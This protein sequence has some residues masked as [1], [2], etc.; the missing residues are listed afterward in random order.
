MKTIIAGSRTI[1]DRVKVMT[2]LDA[3]LEV[4]PDITEVVSGKAIGPDSI[5]AEWARQKNIPVKEFPADWKQHGKPA[6]MIRNTE[7]AK[8]AEALIAFYDGES[9]GT[10]QMISEADKRGLV[11]TA[12]TIS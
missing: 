10:R 11:V 12:I 9:S 5:G 1:T 2:M 7:M 8:Y 3:L 6:G 4:G